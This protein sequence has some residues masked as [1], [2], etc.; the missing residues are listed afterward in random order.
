[1]LTTSSSA[2]SILQRSGRP[3]PNH[4]DCKKGFYFDRDD[5]ALK[6]FAK[7]FKK[8]SD[9]EREHGQKFMTYQNNRGGRIV[10]QEV[11]KPNR[12]EWGTPLEAMKAA[13]ELE[14]TVNQS[15]LIL[16]EMASKHGDAH[17]CDFLESE[18]LTEQV[19]GIKELGDWVTKLKR[20][21][22]GIGVHILDKEIGQ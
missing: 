17:L 9:E 11:A 10:L 3:D 14:K 4:G 18:F 5:I 1:M 12:N 19:E 13:L 22:D 2:C 21:G 8:S 20:A 6:G 16:H 7:F 15:I